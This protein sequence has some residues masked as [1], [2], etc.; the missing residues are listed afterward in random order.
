MDAAAEIMRR[1]DFDEQHPNIY[2][3]AD[4]ERQAYLVFDPG[5]LLSHIKHLRVFH[6]GE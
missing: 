1:M 5:R 6:P 2:K 4:E 3:S